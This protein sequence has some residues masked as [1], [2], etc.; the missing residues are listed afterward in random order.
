M[1]KLRL[2]G[3]HEVRFMSGP[4]GFSIHTYN[5][6]NEYSVSPNMSS[7]AYGINAYVTA[8]SGLAHVAELVKKYAIQCGMYSR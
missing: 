1:L 7:R 6:G 8:Y 5:D 4:I 3:N 2:G